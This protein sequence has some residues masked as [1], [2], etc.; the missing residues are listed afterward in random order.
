MKKLTL[1]ITFIFIGIACFAQKPTKPVYDAALAKKLG[2]DKFGMKRYVMAFLKEGPNRLKDSAARMEL[3][4]AHLKNISKLADEGKLV[5]AGPFLDD[6]SIKGIFIFNVTTLEEAKT[7]TETDP[8]IKAGALI[9]ELHP[10]YCSAALM[11]VVKIH[12]T[13]ES[14][15]FSD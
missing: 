12:H 9:M 1:L 5:V 3:Q 15:N 8:A 2:A 7:L 14:E 6:Q 10:F 11:E 4:M 13:L